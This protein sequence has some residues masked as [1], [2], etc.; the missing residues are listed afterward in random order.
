MPFKEPDKI[1]TYYSIGEVAQ[2]FDVTTSLIRYWENEF[3]VLQPKKSRKGDRFFTSKDIEILKIIYNLVKERGFKLK[4]AKEQ[5]KLQF[6]KTQ[7][8][9][10]VIEKLNHIKA[11]LIALKANL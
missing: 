9:I 11:F 2:M 7:K 4:G 1:K 5:I 8:E 3:D 6:N 10:E